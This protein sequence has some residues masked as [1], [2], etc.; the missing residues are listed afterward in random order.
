MILDEYQKLKKGEKF[1]INWWREPSLLWS[2]I[3][4]RKCVNLR[5]AQAKQEAK[6]INNHQKEPKT[7]IE[8]I[9]K[10]YDKRKVEVEIEI[11]TKKYQSAGYTATGCGTV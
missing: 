6:I 8:K 1:R 11:K 7:Q 9:N 4:A 2:Q 5:I 3:R 10:Y